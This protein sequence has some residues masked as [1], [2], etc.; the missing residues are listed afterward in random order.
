MGYDNQLNQMNEL[1]RLL[2]HTDSTDSNGHR[3]ASR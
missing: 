2:L 3:I 1:D